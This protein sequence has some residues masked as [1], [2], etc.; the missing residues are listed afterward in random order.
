MK[1][2]NLFLVLVLGLAAF[3]QS[4]TTIPQNCEG[5]AIHRTA[6]DS[7]KVYEKVSGRMFTFFDWNTDYVEIPT[8]Q[9]K[10]SLPHVEVKTSDR[11]TFS[12]DSISYTYQTERGRGVDIIKNYRQFASNEDFLDLVE[13]QI[14]EIEMSSL[15]KNIG[16]KYSADSILSHTPTF[17]QEVTSRLNEV[18]HK[19]GFTFLNIKFDLH[20]P[21]AIKAILE[22][23]SKSLQ[24]A[25]AAK[26]EATKAQSRQII[27]EAEAKSRIAEAR[28]DLE[29]AKIQVEKQKL[30]I[31]TYTPQYLEYL[32][33]TAWG[34][35]GC[36]P[37]TVFY[38]G[39][40][41]VDLSK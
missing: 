26:A 31:A 24:Q 9:Q 30:E 37:Q 11:S 1:S 41:R 38:N 19:R 21:E 20:E 2:R 39:S 4:C 40:N 3:A 22:A 27:V 12:I 23:K 34:E 18:F 25:E 5:V 8:Y 7:S 10:G 17:T 29:V 15:L 13:D 36:P 33:I 16:I 6:T 28:A 35:A 14:F 32:R